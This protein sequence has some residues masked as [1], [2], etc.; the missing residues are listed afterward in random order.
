M[1]RRSGVHRAFACL[2]ASSH[3]FCVPELELVFLEMRLLP[4][5][6]E[7]YLIVG[8][9]IDQLFVQTFGLHNALFG[10]FINRKVHNVFNGIPTS[11]RRLQSDCFLKFSGG[12][13]R[14][15]IE[16]AVTNR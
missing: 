16:T 6:S 7:K 3:L 8:F 10:E 1:N 14:T 12:F 15:V 2:L 9:C 5:W 13:L 11:A 4:L